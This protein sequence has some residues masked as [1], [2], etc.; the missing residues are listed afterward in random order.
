VFYSSW[1]QPCNQSKAA[2]LV[3][4]IQNVARG[5]DITITA[6]DNFYLFG[7]ENG[8]ANAYTC[9]LAAGD[10]SETIL[11]MTHI[12]HN[13]WDIPLRFWMQEVVV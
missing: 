9:N 10:Q 11:T 5:A 7:C 1:T 13:R 2:A 12:N 4:H 6:P 3:N 8:S